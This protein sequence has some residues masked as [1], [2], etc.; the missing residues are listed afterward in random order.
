[1]AIGTNERAGT[2]VAQLPELAVDTTFETDHVV[3]QIVVAR[4][5]NGRKVQEIGVGVKVMYPYV[6]TD[7]MCAQ[8]EQQVRQAW[9]EQGR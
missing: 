7:E 6:I 5:Q 3:G 2:A 1:M 4:K 8:A 9:E